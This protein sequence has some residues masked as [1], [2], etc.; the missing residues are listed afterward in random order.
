MELSS[1]YYSI[2]IN[3]KELV[4]RLPEGVMDRIEKQLLKDAIDK[5]GIAFTGIDFVDQEEDKLSFGVF[6]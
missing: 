6:T 2:D 5:Y 4:S 1:K 3:T